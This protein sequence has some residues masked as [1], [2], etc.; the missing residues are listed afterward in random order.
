MILA[1]GIAK[2]LS[3]EKRRAKVEIEIEY[4]QPEENKAIRPRELNKLYH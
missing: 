4:P 3:N 2:S 1:R